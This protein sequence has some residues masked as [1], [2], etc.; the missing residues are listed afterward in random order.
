MA[1]SSGD[2]D[3]Q[4]TCTLSH[5]PQ[6]THSRC[7]S[8]LILTRRTCTVSRNRLGAMCRTAIGDLLS[9]LLFSAKGISLLLPGRRIG[10][11]GLY[12]IYHIYFNKHISTFKGMLWHTNHQFRK[13][14][15]AGASQESSSRGHMTSRRAR[16][17]SGRFFKF[18]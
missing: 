15:A 8:K 6:T 11:T 17:R 4:R 1:A 14:R 16:P 3:L 7:V 2:I 12:M 13:G 10:F 18:Q 9:A 5:A